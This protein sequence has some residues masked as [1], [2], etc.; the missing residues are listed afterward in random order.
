MAVI[1]VRPM[2]VGRAC[3]TR[4]AVVGGM[5]GDAAATNLVE[6]SEI[7]DAQGMVDGIFNALPEIEQGTDMSNLQTDID[8][9]SSA[10]QT[11]GGTSTNMAINQDNSTNQSNNYG[12]KTDMKD[13]GL[14]YAMASAGPFTL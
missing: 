8:D 7:D 5:T 10:A 6:G 14:E 12:A 4:T 1:S 11:P 3:P 2:H 9:A 13:K